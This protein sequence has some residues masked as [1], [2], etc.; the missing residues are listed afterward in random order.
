MPDINVQSKNQ[1]KSKT[2]SQLSQVWQYISAR[3]RKNI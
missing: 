1:I 3:K 2:N